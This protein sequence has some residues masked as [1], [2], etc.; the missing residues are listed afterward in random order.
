MYKNSFISIF[1][2]FLIVFCGES[3]TQENVG[4]VA[5]PETQELSQE[6]QNQKENNTRL[7]D[8]RQSILAEKNIF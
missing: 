7:I 2:S 6:P 1:L 4:S 3:S 5:P 8:K